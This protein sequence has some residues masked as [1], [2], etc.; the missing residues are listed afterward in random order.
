MRALSFAHHNN[1]LRC[2][3]IGAE[4][5]PGEEYVELWGMRFSIT[6]ARKIASGHALI[7][8]TPNNFEQWLSWTH[9]DKQHLNH[10]PTNKGFGIV[11]T[12]PYG[13]GAPMIDGNHR[14]LAAVINRTPFSVVVLNEQESL[15]LLRQSMGTQFADELWQDMRNHPS[16]KQM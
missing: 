3:I 5:I 16:A 8:A 13:I 14:T 10:V 7:S 11:I 6:I 12:L 2:P 15:N 4:D 9:I 1:C